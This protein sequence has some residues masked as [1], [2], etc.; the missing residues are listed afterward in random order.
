MLYRSG[1]L[2]VDTDAFEVR[3]AGRPVDVEPKVFDVLVLLMA[4]PSRVLSKEEL[5]DAVWG[6][7]FVSE[8]ALTTAIKL[9]RQA[10]GD[11]GR[12]QRLIRTVHGRGYRF[13]G[14]LDEVADGTSPD[15]DVDLHPVPP[16][17]YVVSDGASIA[18]QCFGDGPNL[19][20]ILGFATNLE[21][22][23]EHPAIARFLHGLGGFCRVV[24]LDK[25]GTGL[26]DRLGRDEAPPLD[27]RVDDVRVVMDAVGMERASVFGSSEGGSLSVLLAATH[28]E[29]VER[30]VLHGT[31]ARHPWLDRPHDRDL[32][33][34]ERR[35]GSG[36]VYSWLASSM[37]AT[38]AGRRFLGRLERQG[39]TPGTARRL[40]E[41]MSA[42]DVT[43]L[44]PSIH[45][46]A[47]VMHR[48][49]DA[50][51]GIGHAHD[52]VRGMPHAEL[53]ELPG[54]DHFLFSGDTAPILAAVERFV[55][56]SAPAP[57]EDRF[58]ATVVFVGVADTG[59]FTPVP[60][61]LVAVVR[62]G[63]RRHRGELVSVT[64]D[65]L[66]ATFDGPGRA[67]R[68]AC[69]LRDALAPLGTA[70][71]IG[72]HTGEVARRGG[73]LSG[74]AVSVAG[75]LARAADPGSVLA[76]RT[77]T[78]LVAGWGLAF[79]ARNGPTVAGLPVFEVV[80]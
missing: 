65:G 36:R 75:G 66:L 43:A 8:S 39:A 62:D 37:G 79:A 13:V 76:S 26:S 50:V 12:K 5:L 19:V 29:R 38:A 69:D 56:G 61:D 42:I 33:A 71:R 28:P 46:P 21:V 40:V 20:L 15:P 4:N 34:V 52:L 30:L 9:A 11:S 53:V 35:W 74:M 2:E 18:Y 10:I 72:V 73:H 77:V 45:V 16:T 14:P 32:A 60:D 67:V 41:L 70:V 24:V 55:A 1:D 64:G 68:A 31:W 80:V 58:L 6:N 78:E 17:R 48:S 49:E 63:V 57:V 51:Y 54:S 7:R 27:Q 47:L 22:Q 23:W 25:R 3:A 59:G 44:L